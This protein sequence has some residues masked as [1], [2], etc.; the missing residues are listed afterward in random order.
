MLC[1]RSYSY[2]LLC[3]LTLLNLKAWAQTPPADAP[4]LENIPGTTSA[5]A[6][7]LESQ[8]WLEVDIGTISSASVEILKN[9]LQ[10]AE[11]Q[12]LAGLILIIDS[13]GGALDATRS[14]VKDI[15]ASSIPVLSW[16]GPSGAHAG[17]AGAFIGLA[18][19]LI[20]MA[21]G[22]NIGAAHPVSSSGKDIENDGSDL[23][24]KIENDTMAFMESIATLRGRNKEMAVSF[25][26]N[27]LSITAQEA[28]DNKI[29]DFISSDIPSFLRA[30]NGR[31][32]KINENKSISLNT[33]N[34]QTVKFERTIRQELLEILSNS[35]LF[36]LLFI[37]G[38]LGL[39]FEFTH[40]GVIAPG[41]IG[42]ICLILALIASSTLPVNFG[43]LL[44]LIASIAF[45]VAEMFVPSFGVLGIG[46]LVGFVSGSIL[47]F[48]SN[49]QMGLGISLW[50][51]IPAALVLA[52]IGLAF[53][54]LIL[55]NQ[56]S[57]IRSGTEGIVGMQV[58]A[59]EYFV[60][61]KGQVRL[62]GEY[63]NGIELE[64]QMV[65][66]GDRLLVQEVD[67]LTLQ[68]KLLQ[69]QKRN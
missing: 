36:Y 11:S 47:L 63:W 22:T 59:V 6:A 64:H 28:L 68:L 25:V 18:S 26:A 58:E 57:R 54:W 15:L 7:K 27:S 66:P 52:G 56:R 49:N 8:A 32:V 51:I 34:A 61:G 10:Q 5:P 46:G 16:V 4:A 44:L 19:H 53:S 39:A 41:V 67:G 48:D 60:D 24:T 42:A 2:V 31:E 29:I 21:P 55:R 40:P 20:S 30:L 35:E 12:K 17:S 3:L 62:Q 1:T 14:M 50:T 69:A 43:A 13:P 38:L 33:T 45:M 65:K 9:A 23:R 37:A